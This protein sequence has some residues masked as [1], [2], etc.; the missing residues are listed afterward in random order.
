[1]SK[2][3]ISPRTSFCCVA[4]SGRTATGE[5]YIQ[6]LP[7]RGY[8]ITVP[9]RIIRPESQESHRAQTAP[10]VDAGADLNDRVTAA[11]NHREKVS[12]LTRM[13]FGA[14]GIVML[15]ALACGIEWWRESP[16]WPVASGFRQI[17]NDGAIKRLQMM[18][19]GGP[20]AAL[21]SDGARV[22]FSEGSSDA[23]EVA[24]ASATGSETN[25]VSMPVELPS[26]L[27]VSRSR[28]EFLVA[29]SLR[30]GRCSTAL[31]SSL[32]SGDCE[33]S[34]RN[35]RVGC[36][37]V[38][39]RAVVSV[40]TGSR[41]V[42]GEWRRQ[43]IEA[44][45][46]APR[47]RLA[48]TLVSRWKAPSIDDI[49]YTAIY[50]L[51]LGNLFR[52]RRIATV[53]AG[54]AAGG[55][56]TRGI[57][58]HML[59]DMESGRKGFCLSGDTAWPVGRMVAAWQRQLAEKNVPRPRRTSA[60]HRWATKF[61]CAG[62][63]PRRPEAVRNRT[64]S[65]GG[66]AK[67]RQPN[68]T[69]RQLHGGHLCEFC[70]LLSRRP[71]VAVRD[72]SGRYA[73]AS[74]D[75]TAARR[76]SSRSRLW[77]SRS[78]NGRLTDGRSCFTRLVEIANVPFLFRLKAASHGLHRSLVAKCG[79]VG[80]RMVPRSCTATSPSSPSIQEGLLCISSTLKRGRS[81]LCLIQTGCSRLDGRQ[82]ASARR[83]LASRT[84][85]LCCLTSR[86]RH[87]VR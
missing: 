45:G 5:D 71:M 83:R 62:V 87:G 86:Q 44:S 23:P 55:D 82:T 72:I 41:I 36:S 79:R 25:R 17:T 66:V 30:S 68:R 4:N 54:V 51:P 33:A 31:G 76:H 59:R 20:E 50:Q 13:L 7:K 19:L 16:R 1:M 15:M 28:S 6:T 40:R 29:G 80:R 3:G 49:R 27:D 21:F 8:R 74:P 24:E 78:P 69:V 67:V 12:W 14:F 64:G 35:H 32:S 34:Q 22:Y 85:A 47:K 53:A 10:H 52:G 9:V 26:L 39:G 81:T 38:S 46:V 11:L 61:D 37:V 2:R 75:E 58:R 70:G 84:S 56:T 77:R 42:F 65:S 18:Q 43:W 57:H 48:P 73:M 63:Q 60:R